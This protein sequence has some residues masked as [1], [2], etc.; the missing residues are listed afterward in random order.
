MGTQHKIS[1]VVPLALAALLA[2][3]GCRGE[4]YVPGSE[5]PQVGAGTSDAVQTPA[6]DGNALPSDV[7]FEIWVGDGA[8]DP[9]QT[10]DGSGVWDISDHVGRLRGAA[11][12]DAAYYN[13]DLAA[14][15][16]RTDEI[17]IF[18]ISDLNSSYGSLEYRDEVAEAVATIISEQPDL[19]LSTGDMVAGQRSGLDYRG[20]WSAFHSVVSDPLAEAGIPFAVT[21]GN[22]DASGFAR[23][24]QERAIFVSEWLARPPELQWVD[25]SRFPLR[26]SFTMGPAFFVSL[27]ATTV[28]PLDGE[29][30]DWL[31]EQ[32]ARGSSWPATIVF[33]HV[34]LYPFAQEKADEVIGDRALEAL[35][36][37]HGV[38]LFVSGHHHTYYPGRRDELRLVG[39]SCLGTGQRRLIGDNELSPRSI[40]E[41]HV[42]ADGIRTLD[43]YTGPVFE[44]VI[45]RTSLPESVGIDD[46]RVY[47]DDL[48]F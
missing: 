30:M 14:R 33:G 41:I 21:P 35:L 31:N 13:G 36:V 18:V 11:A 29:Q 17:E 44:Y 25:A 1:R 23:F 2:T 19:V 9:G 26:Y 15:A 10:G 22:H 12:E 20:M 5:R 32:L 37:R 4:R 38:D 3:A 8:G 40:L 16:E 42:G 48:P 46:I 7:P 24:E 43:A 39:T 28:G 47:R 34:P 45:P 6:D 27:D